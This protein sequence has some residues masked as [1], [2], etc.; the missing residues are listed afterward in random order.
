LN[1]AYCPSKWFRGDNVVSHIKISEKYSDH[2]ADMLS[3]PLT[4]KLPELLR[5]IGENALAKWLEDSRR[6][7]SWNRVDIAFYTKKING[8]VDALSLVNALYVAASETHKTGRVENGQLRIT[9]RGARK[10][11]GYT[12]NS[13][14][15]SEGVIC[16]V[17]FTKTDSKSRGLFTF[18]LYDKTKEVEANGESDTGKGNVTALEDVDIEY[19]IR[20]ELQIYPNTFLYGRSSE[21]R[22]VLGLSADSDFRDIQTALHNLNPETAETMVA[23][24]MRQLGIKY[25]LR[26]KS[27]DCY[28]S[29]LSEMENFA[30]TCKAHGLSCKKDCVTWL[31]GKWA[32]CELDTMPVADKVKSAHGYT[33]RDIRNS[34]RFIEEVMGLDFTHIPPIALLEFSNAKKNII[35]ETRYLEYHKNKFVGGD[36]TNLYLKNA[37][38]IFPKLAKAI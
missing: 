37:E 26:G 32:S 20:C 22:E 4:Q 13:Y 16:G 18:S 29:I 5:K 21:F 10:T 9:E 2:W 25:M 28:I 30:E 35:D 27:A 38:I 1:A 17:R 11:I 15:T 24:A 3:Y 31:L 7:V 34:Y 8:G 36:N 23:I 19:R 12:V 33:V 14:E 6:K